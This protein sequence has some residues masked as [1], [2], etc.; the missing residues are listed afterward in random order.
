MSIIKWFT[1]DPIRTRR[2]LT[3][4]AIGLT[5]LVVFMIGVSVGN[6]S[7]SS[8]TV[9]ATSPSSP[10]TSSSIT[11]T[12]G[13]PTVDPPIL[14]AVKDVAVPFTEAWLK[15]ANFNN[16]AAWIDTM[17]PYAA[18]GLLTELQLADRGAIPVGP[19]GKPLTV[20]STKTG[21]SIGD[22]LPVQVMLSNKKTLT[23]TVKD[24]T[25]GTLVA[26]LKKN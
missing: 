5:M 15:A 12:T 13:D 23:V 6:S 3:R 26:D 22:T 2:V 4:T 9:A 17:T 1:A 25:D 21:E 18:P 19:N 24:T 11:T 20:T 7:S 16:H 8:K 14:D 10:N